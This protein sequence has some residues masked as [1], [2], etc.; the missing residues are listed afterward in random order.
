MTNLILFLY[1][2]LATV[3][4][5]VAAS[6]AANIYVLEERTR[7]EYSQCRQGIQLANDDYEDTVSNAAKVRDTSI[8]RRKE[9]RDQ[10]LNKLEVKTNKQV[11]NYNKLLDITK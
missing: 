5:A 11:D 3:A 10:N 2:V 4:Q 8:A 6:A 9:L 7:K 1:R